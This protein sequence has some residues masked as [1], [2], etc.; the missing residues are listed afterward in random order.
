MSGSG[1]DAKLFARVRSS[2]FAYPESLRVFHAGAELVAHMIAY[3]PLS[4]GS[5]GVLLEQS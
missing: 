4:M 3:S 5:R 2:T 1:G